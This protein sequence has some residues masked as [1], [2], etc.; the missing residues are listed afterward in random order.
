M[1]ESYI[2]VDKAIALSR[3]LQEQKEKLFAQ[4]D[5]VRRDLRNAVTVGGANAEQR[6]Y[7]QETY[8]LRKRT[9]KS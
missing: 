3:Q 8:P 4:I 1:P 2:D 6:K 7:V 9:V 5:I